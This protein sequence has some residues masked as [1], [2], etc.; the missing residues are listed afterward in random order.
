VILAVL[1][2]RM[3]SARLPGKVLRPIMGRPMLGRQIDRVRRARLID[4]LVIATSTDAS[5]DVVAAFCAAE[6]IDC[7]RGSL[8]DLISRFQGAIRAF[9]PADHIVR[10][11]G[12]CPLAD[13]TVIDACVKLHLNEGAEYTSNSMQRSYPDGLDVE[14]LTMVAFDRLDQESADDDAREHVTTL[15]YRYPERYRLA[16]LVQPHDRSAMRWTVDTLA[17]FSMV[18]TV[19][20]ALLPVNPDFRQ[21]DV[22]RFLA[23]RPDVAAINARA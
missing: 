23:E 19:F 13:S 17:D 12:D 15:V 11:T 4:G 21:E 20:H 8:L 10:L 9:G 2:A 3:S 5:D 14:I 22:V 16:H 1:Q 6:G 18:K 7:H